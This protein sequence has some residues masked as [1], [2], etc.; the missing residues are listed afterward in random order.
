MWR[1]RGWMKDRKETKIYY[2]SFIIVA[3]VRMSL[4]RP[5]ELGLEMME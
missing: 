4:L 1:M 3:T 2:Q 5:N